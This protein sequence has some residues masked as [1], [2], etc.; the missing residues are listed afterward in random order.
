MASS[1]PTLTSVSGGMKV[2]LAADGAS[3]RGVL[4]DSRGNPMASARVTAIPASAFE[5]KDSLAGSV[6]RRSVMSQDDGSF[7]MTAM[8]PGR[9]RVYAFETLD[10]DPSFDQ[11]PLQLRARWT[12]LNLKP[13]ETT[14]VEVTP[15]PQTRQRCISKAMTP[16][17]SARPCNRTGE[18]APLVVGQWMLAFRMSSAPT[19]ST[20]NPTAPP[21]RSCRTIRS[22]QQAELAAFAGPA[23][24]PENTSTTSSDCSQFQELHGDRAFGD[25]AAIIA[26]LADFGSLPV[27]VVAQQGRAPS[28]SCIATSVCQTGG[29]SKSA[30]GVNSR[31]SSGFR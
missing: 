29:L 18:N 7:E 1:T 14:S 10:A 24:S 26:G 30:P 6:W 17:V 27:A 13:K 12:D 23:S 22:A 19:N 11:I 16:T 8:A 3:V 5:A 28:R 20:P 21:T 2:E 31:Q 25:D 4:S 9:Y 15:I